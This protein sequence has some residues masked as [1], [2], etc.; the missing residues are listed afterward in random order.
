M[1]Q[2]TSLFTDKPIQIIEKEDF[3]KKGF[4]YLFLFGA[5]LTALF[6]IYSIINGVVD[7]FDIFSYLTAWQIIRS[8][9]LFFLSL[10]ISVLA[11]ALIVGILYKRA[12]TMLSEKPDILDLLPRILKTLGELLAV[13]PLTI[14]FIALFTGITAGVPFLP[15]LSMADLFSAFSMF[16]LSFALSGIGA[17]GISGYFNQLF[18]IGII[19]FISGI[20]FSFLNIVIFYLFA[21]LFKLV[22]KFLRRE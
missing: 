11:F 8:I 14:G 20:I 19:P 10:I 1:K 15:I 4:R 12:E 7:Y 9:V 5:I 16:D 3:F 18:M 13:F 2:I 17:S 6:A 22:V 21:E